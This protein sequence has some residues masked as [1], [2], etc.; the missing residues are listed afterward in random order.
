MDPAPSADP[1]RRMLETYNELNSSQITEL[2]EVPSPLEF[3]RFWKATQTWN[4]S[5]LKEA[6][7][8]MSVNVAVTPEG[9]ADA[10]TRTENNEILFTKPHEEDQP[11]DEF[12]DYIITQENT[13]R[14]PGQE[15][16]YAQTQNNN[17]PSE[18]PPLS[19]DIPPSLPFIRIALSSFPD[20]TN[21]WIG[22]SY[23]VTSLHKD[24]YQNIYV[25]ILRHKH[26]TL[27]PP[28]FQ[29]CVAET[30]LQAASY[31]R[32]PSG[33]LELQKEDQ[34]VPVALYDPDVPGTGR[35]RYEDL[36]RPM[37]VTLNPGDMLYLPALWYHKVSQS[38]GEEGMSV[39]V[40]YWHDMEFGGSFWPLC[41]FVRDV[42][43]EGR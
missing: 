23:S 22:N 14:L 29:P 7:A 30:L 24:P 40:N 35:E 43:G 1:I 27:L 20:A 18:Y 21:L 11:F 8:G 33:A 19:K 28:L 17:L 16:R 15:I 37:R 4:A 10:P 12:L 31:T 5:T 36:A 42:A 13:G 9:N 39:A 26:F 41:G 25:Q 38:C 3:M 2:Q 34:E 6:M 32:N